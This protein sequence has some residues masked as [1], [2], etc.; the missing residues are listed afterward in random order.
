MANYDSND[1]DWSW[2]GD[3][4]IDQNGDLSDTF[5]DLL[6]SITHEI[7]TIIKSETLD[8]ETDPGI[9]AN[10]SDFQ[11]LANNR[12]VGKLIENRI[13]SSVIDQGLVLNGDFQIRVIPT[14]A[15]EV[16]ISMSLAAAPTLNNGLTSN[17]PLQIHFTYN[18]NENNVF[19]LL[20]DYTQKVKG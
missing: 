14:H 13:K 4:S 2:D 11:G 9:G 10:L 8:W 5:R 19:F 16:L 20:E 18:S 17:E 1:L 3:F 7:Q 12:E 15:N 6:L